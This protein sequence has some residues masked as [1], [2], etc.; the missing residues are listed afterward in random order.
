MTASMLAD[1]LPRQAVPFKR[2]SSTSTFTVDTTQASVMHRLASRLDALPPERQLLA[3]KIYLAAVAVSL[4][5]LVIAGLFAPLTF[6]EPSDGHA[7]PFLRDWN[8]LFMVLVSFPCICILTLTDQRALDDAL[9]IVQSDG[10]VALSGE[11]QE[12]IAANWSRRFKIMNIVGQIVG[13]LLGATVAAIN[14]V[15]Y[16]PDDSDF[17][18]ADGGRLLPIGY[19]YICFIFTFYCAASIYVFRNVTTSVLLK[20]IVSRAKLEMLPFHPDKS[21][22]LRPVGRLGLRNQYALT[23]LGLNVVLLVLISH[24]YLPRS[25]PL[26]ELIVAACAAYVI[27]GPIVFAAPMLPFRDAMLHNKAVLLNE[28]ARRIRVELDDMRAK[29]PSGTIS[30]E[31]FKQVECLRKFYDVTDELPAWPFDAN[32]VRKFSTAYAI[33]IASASYPIVKYAIHY[34]GNSG[35]F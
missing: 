8:T 27:L 5:P 19:A 16:M 15:A 23:L 3:V 26:T 2:P 13:C 28:V 11:D 22:G 6:A 35:N 17:W 10:A 18:I 9:K 12:A 7:L 1:T 30:E 29:L 32:T 24:V 14:L 34:A 33:P 21:G 25:A 31:D 4:V 20:E